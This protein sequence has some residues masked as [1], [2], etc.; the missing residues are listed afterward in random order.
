MA[1]DPS[2]APPRFV[3]ALQSLGRA[4]TRPDV[5]LVETPAPSRIAPF[6]AA[7]DGEVTAPATEASGRFVL[8]HDP[9][10]QDAWEGEFRIVTLVKAQLEAEVAADDLWSDVA[11]SWLTDALVDVPH[12][13]R[14]GT[15]T[16][17]VSR[18]YGELAGR[19]E[20]V[21]VEMR[22]SWTPLETDLEAHIGAW[23]E[24]LASCAG[25]PP[26]PEGV[27]MIRGGAQ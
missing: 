26:L 19:A 8:L 4:R 12:R 10:G 6:A 11:W 17:T 21:Q 13:A 16:R 3:E 7:I 1:V 20:E 23:T 2:Q 15:V 14:G 22:A 27:S 18:A 25:V 5:R 9:S 24:L